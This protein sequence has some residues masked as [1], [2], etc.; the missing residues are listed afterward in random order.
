MI[1]T[2]SEGWNKFSEKVSEIVS[3]VPLTDFR[4]NPVEESD[5]WFKDAVDKLMNL[6]LKLYGLE[7]V[8][9]TEHTATMLVHDELVGRREKIDEAEAI[10][11]SSNLTQEGEK[12]NA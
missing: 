1:K 9:F 6:P 4:G 8:V 10:A 7:N 3:R 12:S 2:N 11:S 5:P